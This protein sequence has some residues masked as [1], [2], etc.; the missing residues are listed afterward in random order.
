MELSGLKARVFG[1][2]AALSLLGACTSGAQLGEERAELGNFRLGHAIVVAENAVVGPASRRAEPEAWEAALTAEIERRFG[3][4][5]GDKFYHVAIAVQG[6]VLAIPGIPIV[7]APKSVLIVGVTIWDDEAQ[8]KLNDTPHRI[9][10]LES[11]SGET[12]V[13][14]G[15]T[16]SAEQQMQNLSE[17][18]VAAIERWIVSK[19]EWFPPRDEAD[20]GQVAGA[21]PEE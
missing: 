20:E 17:N 15:L 8:T 7:A 5:D 19:P 6:Y 14:S 18:A 21:A 9:T 11:L 12:V 4:Y 3:R 13:S 1:A 16:Q 10:V 2:L